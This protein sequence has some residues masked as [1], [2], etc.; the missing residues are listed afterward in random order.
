MRV[1]SIALVAFRGYFYGCPI[2]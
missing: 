2:V 1:N